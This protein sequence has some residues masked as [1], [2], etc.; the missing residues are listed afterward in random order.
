MHQGVLELTGVLDRF[1]AQLLGTGMHPTLCLGNVEVWDHRDRAIYA[2]LD[3]IF[4][5]VQHGWI[6]IQ[7]FQLHLPYRNQAEAV[8]LYNH[9]ATILPYIAAISASSPIYESTFGEFVDNRL[10]F[11]GIN[12]AKIPSI[13]GD[14]IPKPI[15]SFETYRNLTIRKYSADLQKANAPSSLLNKEWINSRGA[16]FRFDLRTIEIRIMDEQECIKSDVALSCFVRALLRGLTQRD[17][18]PLSPPL[19]VHDLQSIIR[20]GLNASVRHPN[21]STARGVCRH[22]LD[23]AYEYA[24]TEERSYLPLIKKRVVGGNLSETIAQHVRTRIQKTDVKE[25]IL[26]IYSKLAEKLIKNEVYA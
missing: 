19:L 11:Y 14:I 20:D 13:T 25:A 24:T 6:N 9:V 16:V 23:L 5:L 12:Q 8:R 18:P 26:S 3:R 7:S 22:L 2:V 15:D 10:Y 1:G 17:E 21:S 4:N